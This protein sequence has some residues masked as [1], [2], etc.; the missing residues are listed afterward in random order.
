M[1][2]FCNDS[3]KDEGNACHNYEQLPLEFR[4]SLYAEVDREV[5]LK[6]ARVVSVSDCNFGYEEFKG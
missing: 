3:A 6:I 5:E 2:E 4:N 1:T